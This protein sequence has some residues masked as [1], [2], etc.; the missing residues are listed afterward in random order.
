MAN[1]RQKKKKERSKILDVLRSMPKDIQQSVGFT[2]KG[3]ITELAAQ[4]QTAIT[5]ATMQKAHEQ[6]MRFLHP[7]GWKQT[8]VSAEVGKR[9]YTEGQKNYIRA[10]K[11]IEEVIGMSADAI[12][13]KYGSDDIEELAT[14]YYVSELNDYSEDELE[15]IEEEFN[16]THGYNIRLAKAQNPFANIDFNQLG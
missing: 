14:Q 8:D 1:K 3:T 6:R 12:K 16:K 10:L 11:V 15:E 13:M 9:K 2:G 7:E 4:A 5:I